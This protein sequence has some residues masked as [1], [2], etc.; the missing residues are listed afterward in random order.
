MY[1]DNLINIKKEFHSEIRNLKSI[2]PKEYWN[3]ESSKFNTAKS[4]VVCAFKI[5]FC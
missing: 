4:D 5:H 1:I 3:V 2:N